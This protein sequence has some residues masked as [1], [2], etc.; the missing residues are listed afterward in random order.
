[1]PENEFEEVAAEDATDQATDQ[2]TEESTVETDT[3]D[4]ETALS[5]SPEEIQDIPELED[6]VVDEPGNDGAVVSPG[7]EVVE[8]PKDEEDEGE[9]ETPKSHVDD[10]DDVDE[11][12]RRL[13]E[14]SEN[15]DIQTELE[16][17]RAEVES[18]REFKYQVEL[19]QKQAL[20]AKYYMLD[21]EDKAQI[22]ENIENYTLDELEAQLALAY[23]A[24]NVD[25][26]VE[27]FVESDSQEEEQDPIVTFELE[28]K[29][30]GMVPPWVE[31]LRKTKQNN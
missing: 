5:D 17:L 25:F 27:G 6:E 16:N 8:P 15:G 12:V 31:S 19:E 3:S 7:P 23:V 9:E 14:H 4:T 21:D 22:I 2:A 13:I 30:A 18:L 29:D 24:K 20:I 10:S 11:T 26:S 1:M 28:N